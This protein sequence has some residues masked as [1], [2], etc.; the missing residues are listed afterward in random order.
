VCIIRIR[1][2]D[3]IEQPLTLKAGVLFIVVGAGLVIFLR[4]ERARMERKQI[5][6]STKGI[7]KPKVGGP[8]SL[9]DQYGVPFSN[10]D[11]K[12]KYALVISSRTLASMSL[13]QGYSYIL[14]TH[15]ARI[16][17]PTN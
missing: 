15:I 5:A 10:E 13:M 9:V 6:N 16:F 11:M 2:A 4:E 7:G 17:A 14:V 8:F 12:D 3:Y 1:S